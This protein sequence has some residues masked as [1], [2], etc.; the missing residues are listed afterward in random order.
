MHVTRHCKK[1][2]TQMPTFCFIFTNS[3]YII[4][5]YF[6][7]QATHVIKKERLIKDAQRTLADTTR[8]FGLDYG[9]IIMSM[10]KDLNFSV[11][12]DDI[13]RMEILILESNNQFDRQSE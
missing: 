7:S 1:F 3:A 13:Q 8:R 4:N 9:Q 11:F 10:R 2:E 12:G 5:Y 6:D